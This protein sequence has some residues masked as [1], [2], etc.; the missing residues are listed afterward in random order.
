[1]FGVPKLM[2]IIPIIALI[3]GL[4]VNHYALKRRAARESRED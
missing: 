3:I 1:M 2:L 4:I